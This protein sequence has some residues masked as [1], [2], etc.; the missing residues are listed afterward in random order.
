M[1]VLFSLIFRVAGI[2]PEMLVEAHGS[3]GSA[4]CLACSFPHSADEIKDVFFIYLFFYYS[5]N[6][7]LIFG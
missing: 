6:N 1:F 4:Q 3:F 7:C 5:H 2:P